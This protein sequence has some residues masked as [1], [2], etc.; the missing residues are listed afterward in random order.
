MESAR[1][2]VRS[3]VVGGEIYVAGGS[4]IT[5]QSDVFEVYDPIANHWHALQSMPDGR[6][7]FGMAGLGLS[8]YIAGGL[9]SWS[10]GKPTATVYA[11]DTK[12]GSWKKRADL[13]E[14]RAGLSLI[15]AGN[16]LYAIGGRGTSASSVY[17]YNPDT[18]QWSTLKAALPETRT[19]HAYA[20]KG[21]RIFVMGG[22]SLSGQA[23]TRVDILDT[24]SGTWTS[25]PGLP[26]AIVSAT[27]DFVGERLHIAGG[28][29]PL[30][31]RTLTSH[32]ALDSGKWISAK[33]LRTARQ[34]LTSATVDG[35]WYVMGGGAGDG[36][37]AVFTETDA[38]EIYTP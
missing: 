13:P 23:L 11:F 1:T 37:L 18:D 30:A 31:H 4:T 25:G 17:R 12:N 29:A 19:G 28:T 27:A 24:K 9:S 34:G 38:V 20:V 2:Q 26:N 35:K 5:G 3:A 16:A 14:A 15:A 36:A 22:R 21:E 7:L 6:E 33:A 10:K 32:W 8:V